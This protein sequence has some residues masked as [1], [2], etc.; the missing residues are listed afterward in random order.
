MKKTQYNEYKQLLQSTIMPSWTTIE[1]NEKSLL[2]LLQWAQKN[3]PRK[4]FKFRACSVNHINAFRQQQI[5]FSNSENMNDEYEAACFCDEKRVFS[6]LN[7]FFNA[8]GMLNFFCQKNGADNFGNSIKTYFGEK[9]YKWFE[10]FLKTNG[11]Q[12]LLNISKNIR[13]F[14]NANFNAKLPLVPQALRKN[15]H[16][17]SFSETIDSPLMWAHYAQQNTGFALEYN[18]TNG[19]YSDCPTC[20]QYNIL[21]KPP[22][23]SWLYPVIYNNEIIDATEY[24]DFLIK[25]SIIQELV[26]KNNLD[27]ETAKIF[28]NTVQ[29][30]DMLTGNKILMHKFSQWKYEKEWRMIVDAEKNKIP[31]SSC[32]LKKKPVAIYLGTKIKDTD[33]F[34]LR[35]IAY[36]QNIPVYKMEHNYHGKKYKLAHKRQ[37]NSLNNLVLK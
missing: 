19:Q 28:L 17:C 8:E 34:I 26:M 5:W 13:C 3:T 27:I 21:C 6:E 20:E 18:F 37:D 2:P 24:I 25:K 31:F 12:A 4:L 10:L 22:K 29:C 33:E 23:T 32:Y 35:N 16:F 9:L 14:I 11:K 30:K 7:C 1:E 15:I 36:Q